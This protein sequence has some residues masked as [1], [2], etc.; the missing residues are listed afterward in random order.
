MKACGV[1]EME[2]IKFMAGCRLSV[3]FGLLLRYFF[4]FFN[5]FGSNIFFLFAVV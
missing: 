2:K 3:E 4:Q 1:F 5:F